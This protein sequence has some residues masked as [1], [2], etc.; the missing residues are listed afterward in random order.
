[1]PA[2]TRNPPQSLRKHFQHARRDFPWLEVGAVGDVQE[3]AQK[4]GWL[5][6]GERVEEVTKGGE[7]NM[8]LTLR[9]RTNQRSM[10]LKQARPWVEKYDFIEAPWDRMLFEQRFYQRAMQFPDLAKMMPRLLGADADAKALLLEDIRGA[11]DLTG[12]YSGAEIADT[13][14]RQLGEWLRVLHSQTRGQS[15]EGFENRE[16]RRLNH[17]HIFHLPLSDEL[18]LDLDEF[19][20]GLQAVADR[21]KADGAYVGRVRE[22]GARYL[23]EP[24][25]DPRRGCLVHGD[26]FPGSWLR[27]DPDAGGRLWIIDPEFCFVGD[28][29]WDLAVAVAHLALADKPWSLAR[30]FLDAACADGSPD[31]RLLARYAACEVMRRLIGVAQLPLSPT[32]GRRADLLERSRETIQRENVEL[33]WSA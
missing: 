27:S 13:D 23:G 2:P 26:Y 10:I 3:L 17:A 20:P 24:P 14:L 12:I 6:P 22:T 28:P 8:N 25:S 4:L 15:A 7:G 21:I 5:L 16:M 32:G 29:E 19:E 9:V 18:D 31:E 30:T 33:L 1:M 11:R